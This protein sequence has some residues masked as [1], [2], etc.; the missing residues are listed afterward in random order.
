MFEL[1]IT[2]FQTLISVKFFRHS[3]D[4]A[5]SRSFWT[6]SIQSSSSTIMF[7]FR[8]SDNKYYFCTKCCEKLHDF[9][10][11]GSWGSWQCGP[12]T[13]LARPGK[14]ETFTTEETLTKQHYHSRFTFHTP[15]QHPISDF[16]VLPEV[17]LTLY[18]CPATL[19]LFW[20][21]YFWCHNNLMML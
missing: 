6:I 8:F 11:L 20:S 18:F 5:A 12:T 15:Y 4:K 16:I 2:Q 10:Q 13:V 3:A 21:G 1:F 14:I 7:H 17:F 9:C 19:L